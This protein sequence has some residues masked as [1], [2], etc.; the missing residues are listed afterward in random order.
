MFLLYTLLGH[1]VLSI[2][3]IVG[4][5]L[6]V[7]VVVRFLTMNSVSLIDARFR[8]CNIDAIYLGYIFQ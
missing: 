2:L 7:V 4:L 5:N 1:D 3:Y 8:L 6:E